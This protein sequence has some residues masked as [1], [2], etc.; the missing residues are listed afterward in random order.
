M[1]EEAPDEIKFLAKGPMMFAHK[2]SSYNINGF[3]FHTLSY[4]RVNLFKIAGLL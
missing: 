1:G 3:N 2:Y 4:V